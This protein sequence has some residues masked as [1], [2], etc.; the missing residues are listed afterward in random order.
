[1][2][3]HQT[4]SKRPQRFLLVAITVATVAAGCSSGP[5]PSD[6]AKEACDLAR[7]VTRGDV[8]AASLFIEANDIRTKASK[9]DITFSEVLSE[10]R[11]SCPDIIEVL[12]F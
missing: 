3:V 12:G 8:G 4:R 9:N 6:I 1:M 10:A 5:S 2:Q 7:R 11:K